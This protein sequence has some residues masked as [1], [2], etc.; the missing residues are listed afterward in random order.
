MASRRAGASMPTPDWRAGIRASLPVCSTAISRA[1]GTTSPSSSWRRY[2]PLDSGHRPE[3][4]ETASMRVLMV[5]L[6]REPDVVLIR[7]RARQIAQLLGFDVQDQTRIATA[8]SEVARNALAYAGGGNVEFHVEGQTRPQLLQV[9]VSDH[10]PGIPHLQ[11]ILAGQYQSS[12]GT[13]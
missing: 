3:R 10:G 2:R 4:S 1:G 9:S 5:T 8:V 7:Q 12:T 11:E 13:G 6:Q